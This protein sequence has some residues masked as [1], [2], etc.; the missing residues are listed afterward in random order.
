MGILDEYEEAL[1]VEATV[2]KMVDR[3]TKHG[4]DSM[5]WY[6][7]SIDVSM[8]GSHPDYETSL[9]ERYIKL[10]NNAASHEIYLPLAKEAYKLASANTAKLKAR[11]VKLFGSLEEEPHG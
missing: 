4:I 3:L 2:K 1:E 5:G 11:I 8:V 10:F 7:L 6:P 9:G